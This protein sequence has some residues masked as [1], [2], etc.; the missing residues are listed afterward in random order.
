MEYK[1][2]LEKV[3]NSIFEGEV[4]KILGYNFYNKNLLLIA[5]TH[6][7]YTYYFKKEYI[8][9]NERLE[10]LGDAVLGL[11]IS[12][13]LMEK[14]PEYKEGTL[15][16]IKSRIVSE[17]I[18]HKIAKELN[19]EKYI[20]LG[21]SE[22]ISNNHRKNSI[23]AD[24]VESI[25]GAVYKDSGVDAAR[26]FIK[27]HFYKYIEKSNNENFL[28]DYKSLLQEVVQKKYKIKPEYRIIKEEGPEHNKMFYVKVSIYNKEYGEGIGKN[29]KEAEQNAAQNALQHIEH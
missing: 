15:T 29:K 22:F 8:L 9:S 5:L 1:N 7:S 16:K 2:S 28:T 26:F 25:I 4:E 20:L 10:F 17:P 19:L 18:L 14:Y 13:I 6:K 24:A 3:K 12:E 23:I 27:K 21:K 11:V